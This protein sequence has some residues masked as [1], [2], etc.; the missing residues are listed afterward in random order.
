MASQPISA[1]QPTPARLVVVHGAI[2][3][4]LATAL[5]AAGLTPLVTAHD[6]SVWAGPPP[7]PTPPAPTLT[8]PPPGRPG[9]DLLTI[10]EA[11]ARLRIGRSSIYRLIDT[12]DLDVVHVGRSARIP[13][14]AIDTLIQ[15]LPRTNSHQT[16]TITSTTTTERRVNHPDVGSSRTTQ[17]KRSA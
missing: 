12:G 10:I 7:T 14:Q 17:R 1:H 6:T 15:R 16:K 11:A 8:T 2:N 3:P 9:P 5:T 13:T 4:T